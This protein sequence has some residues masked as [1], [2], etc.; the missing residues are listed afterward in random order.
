MTL[1]V[2]GVDTFSL[3]RSSAYKELYFPRKSFVSFVHAHHPRSIKVNQIMQLK[4]GF[5][6]EL[7]ILSYLSR[8]CYI[9]RSGHVI[10]V[11]ES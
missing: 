11:I 1:P 9:V 6:T 7:V 2:I 3:S 5:I 10:S 8:W 4:S